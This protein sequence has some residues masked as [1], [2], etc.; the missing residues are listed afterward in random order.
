M[1]PYFKA[2]IRNMKLKI[3]YAF[4]IFC[5]Q[6]FIAATALS[7]TIDDA[8]EGPLNGVWWYGSQQ[9]NMVA[10]TF[11]G[12][13]VIGNFAN[14]KWK[15]IQPTSSTAYTW[16]SFDQKLANYAADGNG[17]Y[18]CVM[19]YTGEAA[20]IRNADNTAAGW[21]QAAGVP[22]FTTLDN[23]TTNYYPDYT[24]P[25]YKTYWYAMINAVIAHIGTLSQSI[26]SKVIIFQSAEGTTGD[27]G[28]Y[29]GTPQNGY[30]LDPQGLTWRTIRTDAWLNTNTQLNI[31]NN[32]PGNKLHLLVNVGNES[33][34]YNYYFTWFGQ[35]TGTIVNAWKKSGNPG[36]G[37]QLNNEAT[38]KASYDPFINTIQ[39]GY[40]CNT[41]KQRSRSELS[42]ETSAGWF[43]EN[44]KW[45]YY[46]M[47]LGCLHY[48][49]DI[50]MLPTSDL[51]NTNS[52][53]G[54]T[55]YKKYAG[56]KDANCSTGAF[57][58]L[59]DGLN[60]NDFTRFPITGSPS[61]PNGTLNNNISRCTSIAASFS[62]AKGYGAEQKDPAAAQGNAINQRSAT[63]LNDVGWDIFPGNY[64]KFITQLNQPAG[65][66]KGGYWKQG[67]NSQECGRFAKGFDNKNGNSI[68]DLYFDIDNNLF[69]GVDAGSQTHDIYL[70]I[71]YLYQGANQNWELKCSKNG[72]G[73][74]PLFKTFVRSDFI[75]DNSFNSNPVAGSWVRA[76]VNITNCYF[77]NKIV[78][79]GLSAADLVLHNPDPANADDI[80]HMLE[81]RKE[82]PVVSQRTITV[83]GPSKDQKAL[84]EEANSNFSRELLVYPN[85]ATDHVNISFKNKKEI[86]LI[87][88]YDLLGRLVT[89]KNVKAY[90][91][92]LSRNELSNV[93][94]IY[95][96][97]ATSEGKQF[98]ARLKL[99]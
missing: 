27:I 88:V 12:Q 35:Q 10:P 7:Q 41:T 70:Y 43:T 99:N 47:A 53:A 32:Q 37:Y 65:L 73:G 44:P 57:C 63:A 83:N 34:D 16:T 18:I 95:F 66:Y 55:F 81:I 80:F 31:Y 20:P 23:G 45:N 28:P 71:T 2:K 69:S 85:P 48:G 22:Q 61:F 54:L 50:W 13:S 51:Q 62:P 75:N 6:F 17:K 97:N 33:V 14:F 21:L 86:S 91:V 79:A 24:D 59:R 93:A 60:A 72:A 58:A 76:Y 9:I 90:S 42:D 1:K 39:S 68:N 46:W 29:K 98:T 5:L 3:F 64:E 77:N 36:H 84:M 19:V 94:G 25:D 8:G 56:A 96:I 4:A 78:V 40:A 89:Q 11:N 38:A 74:N 87:R 49:L 52:W 15:D 30:T 92:S 26:R 82:A 67:D